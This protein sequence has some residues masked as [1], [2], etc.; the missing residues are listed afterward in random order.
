MTELA[1]TLAREAGLPFRGAHTLVAALVRHAQAQGL[2]PAD[3]S[4][5][6]LRHVALDTLGREV[7]LSD[8][9]FERALDPWAFVN[10]RDL[11]GGAAPSA[12]AAVLDAQERAIGE[13]HAWL[14]TARTTLAKADQL[15]SDE[16]EALTAQTPADI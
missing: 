14:E 3:L 1:D 12:T 11:P 7:V 15:L 6:S 5:D 9:A 4:A 13:D 16:V 8:E 2:A 10:A